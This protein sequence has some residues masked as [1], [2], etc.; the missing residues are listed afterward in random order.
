[1]KKKVLF[2]KFLNRNINEKILRAP[3]CMTCMAQFRWIM[4]A[5]GMNKNMRT[6]QTTV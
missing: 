4:R 2:T 1:M 6:S 5:V 3:R